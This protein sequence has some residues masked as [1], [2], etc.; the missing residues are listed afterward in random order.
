[1]KKL[2][3]PYLLRDNCIL[4][5]N[6]TIK[7]WG[8]APMDS[9][10]SL[11]YEDVQLETY[12]NHEDGYFEFA[13]PP[14]K[15]GGPV[16]IEIFTPEERIQFQNV[17][18]GDV[19]LLAGQS[20]MQLWMG[21]LKEK[22]V[23]ELATADNSQIRFFMVP[24]KYQFHEKATELTGGAWQAAVGENLVNLSGIGYFFAKREFAQAK[25]PIGLVQT[26]IGGT[27]IRAWL[28]EDT[29]NLMGELPFDFAGISEKILQSRVAENENYQKQFALMADA[30]DVGY[31]ENWQRPTSER[32]QWHKV[33]LDECWALEDWLPGIVW[34]KK[35]VRVPDELVGKAGWLKL[36]TFMDADETYI[37]G[38]L[39]GQTEYQYPP[40]NYAIQKVKKEFEITIRLHIFGHA[41]GPRQGKKHV[42][43]I[44]NVDFNLDEEGA[45]YFRRGCFLP[46]KRESIF[47]QYLPSG[48][49]NGM[50]YP[51]RNTVFNGILWYQGES[52]TKNPTNYGKAFV[53]L[54]QEWRRL[55]NAPQLP[56]L[57]VQ[58]PNCGI[59]QNCWPILRNEQLNGLLLDNTAMIIALGLG[60]DNDL[61]PLNKHQIAN[62]LVAARMAM[63]K[64]RNGYA[65]GPVATKAFIADS[66]IVVRFNLFDANKLVLKAGTFELD[67]R[68]EV[69]KLGSFFARRNVLKIALPKSI[70]I[71]HG[72]SIRYAWNNT[73]SIFII[74]DLGK[75]AAPF[76]LPISKFENMDQIFSELY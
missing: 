11:R 69:I 10:V 56:F 44:G 58:L 14:H 22:Y 36:G 39:I 46:M 18:F 26:A 42:L 51:I 59:E 16:T 43:T 57:F 20:N 73:P 23:D 50:I 15:A 13:I 53:K 27:P 67:N 72:A 61:H 65:N 24:E 63:V 75:P 1:M 41:G 6:Q 2:F 25:V 4:Q 19:Y 21:R 7:F 28:S 71:H 30:T 38:K 37:D 33:Q 76:E 54:I 70:T 9:P 17:L 40:R 64:Y 31:R 48:L 45:W 55:F 29:L 66:N 74:N 49:F 34:L 52:D 32:T 35:R 8:Y 12:S 60:E 3:V 5:R 47:P 68:T 62:E